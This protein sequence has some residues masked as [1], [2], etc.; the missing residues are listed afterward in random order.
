MATSEAQKRA[1]L[2]YQKKSVR[3]LSVKFFPDDEELWEHVQAQ[4]NKNGYVKSLIRAD[5]ERT[6]QNAVE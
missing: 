4:P 5:M 6:A 3:Q 1:S 2:N